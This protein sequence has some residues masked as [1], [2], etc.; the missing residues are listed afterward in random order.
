MGEFK[1]KFNW[2]AFSGNY[3][4]IPIVQRLLI[5]SI[6]TAANMSFASAIVAI[7]ILLTSI[8]ILAVK[9]PFVQGYEN[10]RSILTNVFSI[11]VLSMYTAYSIGG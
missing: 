9:K 10:Y 1:D 8:I 11:L 5:G 3:Y 4:I 2:S 6:I 7:V